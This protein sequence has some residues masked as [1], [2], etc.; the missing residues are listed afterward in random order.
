MQLTLTT[1]LTAFASL[2][3]TLFVMHFFAHVLRT[4]ITNLNA[5]FI[6]VL[7]TSL[8]MAAAIQFTPNSSM[9]PEHMQFMVAVGISTLVYSAF[10]NAPL[11]KSIF[12]AAT[13]FMVQILTLIGFSF[14]VNVAQAATLM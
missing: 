3:A 7:S 1:V 4:H 6:C 12:L 5:C 2:A 10:L 13:N 14:A 9:Q 11:F 8:I